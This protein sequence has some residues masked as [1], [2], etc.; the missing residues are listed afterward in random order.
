M[1]LPV[2]ISSLLN[3]LTVESERLELKKGWNPLEVLKSLCAFANDINNIG[4]GYIIIG[5]S[6]DNGKPMLPP[7]G[8]TQKEADDI[9]KQL[10]NLGKSAITPEYIP[11]AVPYIVD[12]Q[13]VLVIWAWGGH[14]RP[15][16]AKTSLKKD[17]TET[18][19]YIRRNSCS[20]KAT[21]P[22][23]DA[24][25]S[26][27]MSPPFDDRENYFSK[28]TDLSKELIIDYLRDVGSDLVKTAGRLSI[29]DLGRCL[30]IVSGPKEMLRPLNV[31][32][33]FFC[34][35]PWRFFPLT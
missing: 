32:L 16:A 26:I 21:K 7:V 27:S 14:D 25:L 11:R 3:G 15:Y 17:S 31:G 1:D 29:D 6:E 35:E 19:Y 4:G 33:M 9:Q 8:I 34:L 20:V 22:E 2:S 18:A 10:L 5:V 13:L 28:S 23:L 24:L 30:H 12:G